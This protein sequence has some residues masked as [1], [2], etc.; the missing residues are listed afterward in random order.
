M[1]LNAG[2]SRQ[3]SMSMALVALGI[4]LLVQISSYA[5][6]VA[7]ALFTRVPVRPDGH[8]ADQGRNHLA[9]RHHTALAGDRRT[10]GRQTVAAHPGATE[11]GGGEPAPGRP[12]NLAARATS[13][14]HAMGETAQLVDDFNQ[15]AARLQ[16]MA[17]HRAFWNAAIAHELRTPVTILR[18]RLQGITEGVFAPEQSQ[19]QSLLTQV[20]G[21]G[22]L[23]EDLRTVALA[24]SGHLPLQRLAPIWQKK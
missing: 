4:I 6:R 14:E 20:E 7:A 22:R 2:I 8:L 11:F 10:G 16:D 5:I 1:K 23:I 15:M 3:I 19:F 21:L 12:G 9:G 17:Q 13:D 24:E 18:G